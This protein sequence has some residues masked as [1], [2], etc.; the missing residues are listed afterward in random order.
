M[1]LHERTRPASVWSVVA[2]MV[3]AQMLIWLDNSIL[4]VAMTTLADPVSGL[5]AGSGDLEW[6]ASSYTLVFAST[7]IAGG[8]LADR[9][10]PRT[11]LRTGLVVFAVASAVGAYAAEPMQL[12]VARG[13][14]GA[15]SGLLMPATLSIIVRLTPAAQ[16]TRAIAIWGS[17]SGLGVA[18][19][20]VA[21]G[22]LLSQFWWGSV[23]LINVPVVVACLIGV[24]AVVPAAHG[25]GHRQLDLP[26]LALSILGFGGVVYGVIEVGQQVPWTSPR[27]Y[28]PVLGGV[29]L[30]AAF[31][32]NQR[33]S[34]APSIDLRLLSQR[35]FAAGNIVLLLAFM[36]LSGQLFF[37]AFYLQGPRGL[38]PQTAGTI[39]V[40]AAAG[41]IL[42]SLL[43]P[44]ASRLVSVR[45]TTAAGVLACGATYVSYLWFDQRTPLVSI[46]VM[47]LVQGFGMGILGTPLTVAMMSD[48]P[49]HLTGAGSAIGSVTRQLGSMLGV[50]VTG[51]L[52]A[53]EYRYE[54]APALARLPAQHQEQA[55]TSVEA[56]RA[57]SRSLG[58][59]TLA[60]AAD[61]AFLSAMHTAAILTALLT[62]LG[63]V[64]AAVGLYV[65]GRHRIDRRTAAQRSAGPTRRGSVPFPTG[66]AP[67]REL[68]GHRRGGQHRRSRVAPP[69]ARRPPRHGAAP[70]WSATRTT[71]WH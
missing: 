18:I 43:A 35:R 51:S 2:V 45:W 36:G 16:R 34:A 55:R 28:A 8:A 40:A 53:A 3:S 69:N 7:L 30:I 38:T 56:A 32:L 46:G 1:M 12:I 19:G 27:A 50:A 20:P 22:A 5:G 17:S 33:W 10:G 49:P 29:A 44:A 42:G 63:F 4:N 41:I 61:R 15:G 6:I 65:G 54:L 58:L 39:M 71:G 26:S 68:V 59:P 62:V 67:P 37:A 14:M 25:G 24:A 11:I 52:L 48:V 21:G 64:V 9:F 70:R 66:S 13:F 60:E 47:L 31:V 23:L 57:L